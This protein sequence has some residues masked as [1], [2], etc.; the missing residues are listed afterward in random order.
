MKRVIKDYKSIGMDLLQLLIKSYPDGIYEEDL[1]KITK[2]DGKKI[3]VVEL[4]TDD[5]IYLIKMDREM[6]SQMDSFT[7]DFEGL[8]PYSDGYS[9]GV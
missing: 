3:N 9:G 2:P 1:I 8:D 4:R 6:Q 5:T 7:G